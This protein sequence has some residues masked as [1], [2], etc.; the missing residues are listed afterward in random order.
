MESC[1]ISNE[2]SP[3]TRTDHP[4]IHMEPQKSPICQRNL[5]KKKKKRGRLEILPSHTNFQSYSNQDC[6]VLAQKGR[7]DK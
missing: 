7:A 6:M 5:E 1:K 2:I 4:K 3:R